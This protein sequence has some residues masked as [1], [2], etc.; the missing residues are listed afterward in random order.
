MTVQH[1]FPDSSSPSADNKQTASSGFQPWQDPVIYPGLYGPSGIDVMSV[2]VR[3]HHSAHVALCRMLISLQFRVFARP[4]PKVELGP[5]D[6]SAALTVCNLDLPGNPIIYA[7]EAFAELT[8]YTIQE[9]V[10]KNPGFLHSPQTLYA[11]PGTLPDNNS[12]A[13]QSLD[14]AVASRNEIQLHITNYKKDGQ[15]FTNLLSMIPISLPDD[16]TQ[17]CVGFHV[18]SD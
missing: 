5:V 8:G 9:V 3:S 4:N 11:S 16:E 6:C 15:Q 14:Q 18:A 7:N 1:N 2:L 13:I 12:G 17:Y 10:G